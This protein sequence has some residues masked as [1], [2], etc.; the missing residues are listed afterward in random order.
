M[1]AADSGKAQP[2]HKSVERPP[3][4][5]AE[6]QV[7]TVKMSGRACFWAGGSLGHLFLSSQLWFQPVWDGAA[8]VHMQWVP[9]R[10]D[11]VLGSEHPP[12]HT[13]STQHVWYCK[14][15]SGFIIW[16]FCLSLNIRCMCCPTCDATWN[17][18]IQFWRKK[19]GTYCNELMIR[20]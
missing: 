6:T 9:L 18:L 5:P 1:D 14:A 2:A 4:Q 19:G 7:G 13:G 17:I 8:T 20:I 15:V 12:C 3:G 10:G 16:M 11:G